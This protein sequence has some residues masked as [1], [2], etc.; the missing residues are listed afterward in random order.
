M[1]SLEFRRASL[2]I[3]G[4]PKGAPLEGITCSVFA[5]HTSPQAKLFEPFLD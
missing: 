4:F 1:V 3:Y 5:W 2:K